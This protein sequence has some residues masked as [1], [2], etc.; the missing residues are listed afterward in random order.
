MLSSGQLIFTGISDKVLT[1]VEK[2][3]IEEQNIGGVILFTKNYES[4]AQLAELVNSIQQ[5]RQNFPLFIAT[6][7]EGGRVIR[8]KKHFTQFPPMQDIAMLDSPKICFEVHQIMA[9]ELAACGINV[10]L[11]PCCDVLTNP[12]NKAIGDRAFSDRPDVVEKFVSSAIRGL[13]TNNILACA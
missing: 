9:Q 11:T 6:D 10:N 5:L 2:K 1:S 12:A 8:F 3:F 13:Q 7:H 4:P